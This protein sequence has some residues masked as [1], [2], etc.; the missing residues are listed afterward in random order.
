[1]RIRMAV[2]ALAGAT[3]LGGMASAAHGAPG[4]NGTIKID[5]EA[6]DTHPDNEPHVGCGFEVDFYGFDK[7]DL[8]ADVAFAVQ[9]PTGQEVV[10]RDRV[11]IGEDSAGGGTD[12][13]AERGYDLSNVVASLKAQ[14]QQGFHVK[15]TV[16]ADGSKGA[17]TKHK[18]FWVRR[19]ETETP[20][21]PTT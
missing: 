16:H 11:F 6:F 20:P 13:D 2:A 9:P 18:V 5:N 19:C 1:M 17:D 8:Y 3:L 21:E 7:G 15:L 4:N 12:L 10:L 14:P